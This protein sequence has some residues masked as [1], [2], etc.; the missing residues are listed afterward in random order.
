MTASFPVEERYGITQQVRR[1]AVSVSSN[2]A[3]G[4]GRATTRAL[5]SF[6]SYS[7]GSVKEAESL[8]LV[9]Q[10]LDLLAPARAETAMRLTEEVSRMLSAFQRHLKAR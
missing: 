2:I 10:R 8:L 5:I 7:R 4:S 1:A 9:S 3:E 6:L